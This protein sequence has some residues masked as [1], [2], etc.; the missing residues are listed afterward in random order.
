MFCLRWTPS[1][2]NAKQVSTDQLSELDVIGNCVA[3]ALAV[4]GA[5]SGVL[6]DSAVLQYTRMC[7]LVSMVQ[8]R[9]VSI[10]MHVSSGERHVKCDPLPRLGSGAHILA[11]PHRLSKLG[12]VW[13]CSECA[14][15]C[16]AGAVDFR[17]WLVR[18]QPDLAMRAVVREQAARPVSVPGGRVVRVGKLVLHDTHQLAVYR[19]LWYCKVCGA[20]ATAKAKKLTRP[21]TRELT[22]HGKRVL[23]SISRGTRAPPEGLRVW[24]DEE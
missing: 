23:S 10:L 8:A 21:C 6:P 1:H 9:A 17:N 20:V 14:Q 4:I 5:R 13:S 7:E 18:C 15:S 3:D 2:V 16:H 11:S 24:P 19:Q 22:V 12:S